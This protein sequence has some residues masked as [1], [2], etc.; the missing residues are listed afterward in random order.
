MPRWQPTH[1]E[2]DAIIAAVEREA[3]ADAALADNLLFH[4]LYHHERGIYPRR[5]AK[6]VWRFE[7]G[8]WVRYKRNMSR[9]EWIEEHFP[10]R[11]IDGRIVTM[12][13][14][15]AQRMIECEML[16]ME[17]AGVAVRI[18]L[19]KSRQ[20]GG[21]TFAEACVY[22]LTLRGEHVRGLVVAHN[23][24]TSKILLGISDVAR[25]QMEKLTNEHGTRIP[26]NFKMKSKASYSLEWE[27]PIHGQVL[28][29][30]AATEGAGI[31][32]TRTIVHFSEGARYPPDS[33]VHQGV[34]PSLPN[35]PGTY[36]FDESTAYGDTGKFHDDFQKAWRNRNVPYGERTNAWAA[37]FFPWFMHPLY[38]WT[39]AYGFGKPLPA[40]KEAEILATL[41]DD[42]KKV[43][44]KK[45][46]VRWTPDAEWIQEERWGTPKLVWEDGKLV[47]TERA[48]E[49]MREAKVA[50]KRRGG[51]MVWRRVGVGLQTVTVNQLAWR[52]ARLEDKDMGGDIKKFDQDYPWC[53]EVAFMASGNPVF[54]PEWVNEQIE[55]ARSIPVVFRGWVVDSRQDEAEDGKMTGS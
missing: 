55:K 45:I 26:W 30:S 41:T 22:E 29:T 52:R 8:E 2:L 28:I 19:L 23:Q 27:K 3:G 5:G 53:P 11:D 4:R 25:A 47:G 1:E 24:D 44:G 12:K 14:N 33:G 46:L 15:P 35:R 32:G 49:G 10:L 17:R 13:L 36:A 37:L 51:K 31:G 42:E 48:T 7:G 9:R 6:A 18:Q 40:P 21:S 16:R 34:M 20:I 39:A 50:G 54:D 43:L 38:T